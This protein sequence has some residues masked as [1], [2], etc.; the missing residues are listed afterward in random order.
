M[1]AEQPERY[2]MH[3]KGDNRMYNVYLCSAIDPLL[4]QGTKLREATSKNNVSFVQGIAYACAE[5]IR[6]F[7]EPTY[8]T[9][10]IKGAGLTIADLKRAGTDEYDLA[11]LEAAIKEIVP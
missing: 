6:A 7:D 5:L 2:L 3:P 9:E 4:A 10:I 1:S 11:P 8:A